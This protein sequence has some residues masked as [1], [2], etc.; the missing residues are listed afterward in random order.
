MGSV[1][2]FVKFITL[3]YVRGCADDKVR[4]RQII[5][6]LWMRGT[7]EKQSK[8]REGIIKYVVFRNDAFCVAVF[9][10]LRRP[11]LQ[12]CASMDN[13]TR[14]FFERARVCVRCKCNLPHYSYIQALQVEVVNN[15][16]SC[17]I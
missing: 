14:F 8:S 2:C 17:E 10:F 11:S 16:M 6:V 12:R 9:F 4:D 3:I 13:R 1:V 5:D 15:F 7:G